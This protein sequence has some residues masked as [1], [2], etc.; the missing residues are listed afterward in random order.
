MS[1]GRHVPID[2]PRACEQHLT[3][4]IADIGERSSETDEQYAHELFVALVL[5]MERLNQLDESSQRICERKKRI[6]GYI[7]GIWLNRQ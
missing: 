1:R 6:A 5:A 7:V 3:A 2:L 4:A